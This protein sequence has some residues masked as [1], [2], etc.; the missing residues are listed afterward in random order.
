MKFNSLHQNSSVSSRIRTDGMKFFNAYAIL[1]LLSLHSLFDCESY[2]LPNKHLIIEVRLEIGNHM[3]W[4]SIN[5]KSYNIFQE[6]PKFCK[7]IFM[8]KPTRVSQFNFNLRHNL[9]RYY[10]PLMPLK[11][12][13]VCTKNCKTATDCLSFEKGQFW[14]SLPNVKKMDLNLLMH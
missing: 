2:L 12:M 14:E 6:R 13:K 11:V 9:R 10:D 1:A 5:S 4:L 3:E 7:V 8:Q